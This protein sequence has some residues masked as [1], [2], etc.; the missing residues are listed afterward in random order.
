MVDVASTDA[1]DSAGADLPGAVDL[2]SADLPDAAQSV[3]V[4][5]QLADSAVVL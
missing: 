4:A 1:V 2:A 5:E 3:A